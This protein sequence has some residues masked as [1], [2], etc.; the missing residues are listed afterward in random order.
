MVYLFTEAIGDAAVQTDVRPSEFVGLHSTAAGKAILAH[1]SEERVDKIIQD[2][3][4]ATSRAGFGL[5]G[6]A[7]RPE[8]TG[9]V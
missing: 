9:D 1:Y 6:S 7:L 5:R 2:G 3:T 8:P 4:A